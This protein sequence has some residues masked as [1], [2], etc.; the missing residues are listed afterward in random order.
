MATWF[1]PAP[2]LSIFFGAALDGGRVKSAYETY[3]RLAA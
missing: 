2:V 3:D 1:L